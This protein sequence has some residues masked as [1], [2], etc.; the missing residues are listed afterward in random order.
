ML[1]FA[2]DIE[3]L[4]DALSLPA[5]DLIGVSAG[6]PYALAAAHAMPERVRRVAICSSLSPLCAPHETRG[7]A[8]RNR[9]ALSLLAN[10]PEL[11]VALGDA[12]LP[13][14]R[15][16]PGL[17]SRVIAAGAS[18]DER[19]AL[20]E[21]AERLAAGASFLDAASGGVGGMVED[22]LICGRA[23][24]FSPRAVSAEV[25]LWH[26]LADRLVRVDHALE[27]AATLPRCEVFFD[28]DEGHHF[29]RRRFAEIL[30]R[31]V[32]A[33]RRSVSAA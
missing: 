30:A 7:L 13:I 5:F 17:L 18:R 32:G 10:A 24:G 2:A 25:Q 23:W 11:C 12:A 1:D 19:P 9:I 15:R 27:L 20:R 31:L 26:G 22:Y 29:F 28:P 21:G 3:E 4:A 16:N 8:L 33:R 14:V 6:G